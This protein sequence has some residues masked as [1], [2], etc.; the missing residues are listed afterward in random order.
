MKT[1]ARYLT[2]TALFTALIAVCAYLNVGVFPGVP[3][4]LQTFALFLAC[5]VLGWKQAELCVALYLALGAAGLPVFSG[6]RGG[7]GVL[8]GATGGYLWGF[9]LLPL[10]YGGLLR[11]FGG[12][13]LSRVLCAFAGL[14]ACYLAGT[15]WLVYGYA[16][17]TDSFPR[18]LLLYV[19]P[20][21]VPDLIKLLLADRLAEALKKRGKL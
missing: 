1:S 5:F 15:L 7:V 21:L 17:F 13:W 14:L 16:A 11:L 2:R 20:F 6:F 10:V 18:A 9:L 12:T 8:F 3:F 19:L 4:T